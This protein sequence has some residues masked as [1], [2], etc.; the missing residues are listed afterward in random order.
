MDDQIGLTLKFN[1]IEQW[2][3]S[4]KR[5]AE[6]DE[7]IQVGDDTVDQQTPP[8]KKNKIS[9]QPVR[10]DNTTDTPHVPQKIVK[11]SQTQRLRERYNKKSQQYREKNKAKNTN[12][13]SD[14]NNS[15]ISTDAR[16]NNNNNNT[17]HA[18]ARIENQHERNSMLFEK[19][20]IYVV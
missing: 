13:T 1:G 10:E 20:R 7:T 16:T 14:G 5:R 15:E 17:P 18:Q 4:I 2:R 6:N 19:M 12:E 3:K 9:I 11:K 8:A